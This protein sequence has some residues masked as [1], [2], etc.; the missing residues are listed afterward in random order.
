MKK[1]LLF[2]ACLLFSIPC[3]SQWHH[4]HPQVKPPHVVHFY[5]APS[6]AAP[7][8]GPSYGPVLV[9]PSPFFMQPMPRIERRCEL[10][11]DRDWR[12]NFLVDRFG[13]PLLREY[14]YNVEVW[15]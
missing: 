10:V 8:Y 2:L 1:A 14:C 11:Q 6:Y 15:R 9:T 12:G 3:F 4:T 7:W 13:R 5:T